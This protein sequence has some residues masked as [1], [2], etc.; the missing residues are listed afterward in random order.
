VLCLR[1]GDASTFK[2]T[3]LGSISTFY[4]FKQM[5]STWAKFYNS[6]LEL[7]SFTG[8]QGGTTSFGSP[9]MLNNDEI[10]SPLK[11]SAKV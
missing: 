7:V 9:T 1:A 6:P 5:T 2:Q 4:P 10:D 8:G 11:T 3:E